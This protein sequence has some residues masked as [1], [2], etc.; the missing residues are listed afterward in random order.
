MTYIEKLQKLNDYE[1]LLPKSAR[2]EMKVAGKLIANQ[3]IKDAM[4]DG[5]IEQLSNV[6]CLPGVVE[7]VV[8]LPD[9]HFGY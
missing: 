1:W 8:A 7:P 9:A 2:K 4:E 3:S 6:C 5:T